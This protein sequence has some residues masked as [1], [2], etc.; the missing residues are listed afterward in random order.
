LLIDSIPSL[1][2]RKPLKI[3]EGITHDPRNPPPGC[4]FQLRC[5]FVMDECRKVAPPVQEIRPG[6]KVAC[7]LYKEQADGS[8]VDVRDIA[9]NS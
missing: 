8:F 3:T 1:T 7:Y 6:Q 9:R 4:I 5:P 2:E